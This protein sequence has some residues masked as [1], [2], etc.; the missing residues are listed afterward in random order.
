MK[1][2]RFNLIVLVILLHSYSVA[3]LANSITVRAC[4][5]I[6]W[7]P[8]NWEADGTIEGVGV[9]VA[10]QFFTEQ[11][12][13]LQLVVLNSWV[14][15]LKFVEAGEI[16][17]A[18]AAY[19][20][21]Q[22]AQYA[23]YVEDA[24]GYD[25]MRMIVN[26]SSDLT[27]TSFN[28]LRPYR[29]GG[30][31][32][33]SYGEQFDTF[34]KTLDAQHWQ[35]VSRVEQNLSKLAVGRID[36]APMNPWNMEVLLLQLKR[37]KLIA[38]NVQLK[39]VGEPMAHNGLYYMFSKKSNRYKDFGIAMNSFIKQLKSSGKMDEIFDRSFE[40]YKASVNVN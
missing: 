8:F 18:I 10:K 1:Y 22:R 7:V 24:I 39:A 33:D 34:K 12:T 35:E 28:E 31:I 29:G 14:R 36:Y 32:G 17:L 15:C 2:S 23:V 9:E 5:S 40:Q 16:D 38:S 26:N 25:V 20:T 13:E 6:I 3:S 37:E 4:S 19:K 27:F 30:V 21:E 11:K